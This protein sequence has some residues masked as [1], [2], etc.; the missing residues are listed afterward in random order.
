MTEQ[1]RHRLFEAAAEQHSGANV[2][3]LASHPDSDG[4]S[5]GQVRYWELEALRQSTLTGGP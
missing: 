1:G 5:G 2:R 3:S 4:G